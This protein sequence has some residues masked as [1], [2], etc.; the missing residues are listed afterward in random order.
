MVPSVTV[1][2]L[3]E[4]AT[5]LVVTMPVS[6]PEVPAFN[7]PNNVVTTD[8]PGTKTEG[9]AVASLLETLGLLVKSITF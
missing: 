2:A 9:I 3:V 5:A 7:V 8:M 6:P 1:M 4:M